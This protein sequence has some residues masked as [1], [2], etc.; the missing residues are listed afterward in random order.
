MQNNLLSIFK[1]ITPDNIKNI[2]LIEDS[3]R[4]FIELLQEHCSISSDIKIALSERTTPSISEELPK[5]YLWDYFSMIENLKNSKVISQKFKN[6]NLILKPSLYPTGLPY[7][8]DRL[9]INYFTV[10]EPGGV[11]STE[12][13][14]DLNINYFPYSEKLN[15]LQGNMLQNR[16]ENYYVNR[17]FKQSKGLKKGVKFIYDILNEHLVEPDE[18]LELNFQE[19][20]NPFELQISGSIDKDIYRESV[21]YLAHP[22]GFTY[23]YNYIS[24]LKFEDNYSLIKSYKINQLEVRCLSGNVEVYDKEVESIIEKVD[25]LK[26]IFKDKYYLL[27]KNDIVKYYDNL[28]NLIK[29]YPEGNHCSIYLDYEIVNTS[30][31]SD[32]MNSHFDLDLE[33][34]DVPD[35]SD[36]IAFFETETFKNNMLVSDIYGKPIGTELISND[37]NQFETVSIKNKVTSFTSELYTDTFG[38]ISEDYSVQEIQ[39]PSGS[40]G[41]LFDSSNLN[42]SI[43][44]VVTG[45]LEDTFNT[46][47]E[48]FSIEII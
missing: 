40:T 10:G 21:A 13:G 26:I 39:E 4:I 18:R 28:D 6:W 16:A 34:E 42:E 15:V 33:T 46:C 14:D 27:Q 45:Y 11:L 5:I 1:A 30:T 32:D 35:I 37:S 48:E 44:S 41:E 22:L 43:S 12:A 38:E 20:G 7:I 9:Y 19:T 17:L 31:L 8:G 24:Q 47:T 29:I 25:Y 2:P 3:S 36:F 23:V